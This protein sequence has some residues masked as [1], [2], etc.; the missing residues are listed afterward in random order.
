MIFLSN[1]RPGDPLTILFYII[2]Y[3]V[4]DHRRHLFEEMAS[5]SNKRMRV[6]IDAHDGKYKSTLFQNVE[7]FCFKKIN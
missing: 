5:V 6:F 1:Q 3:I 2:L 4:I 7:I